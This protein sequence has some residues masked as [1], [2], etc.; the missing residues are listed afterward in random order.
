MPGQAKVLTSKEIASVFRV[1]KSN[2]DK[3]IFA[4]GLYAGLRVGEIIRLKPEQV[5]TGDGGIKNILKIV[6]L[7][8]KNTVYSDIP[9]HP[10]LRE[11]LKHYYQDQAPLGWGSGWLFPSDQSTHGHLGRC[12]AH[13]VLKEAFDTIRLEGAST[14]SMRRTCLTNMSRAGVPLRTIQDISGHSNLGQL[15]EYL[16]V[17]PADKHHA[18]SVLKY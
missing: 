14:H 17:D 2:R 7:K 16:A 13:N 12:Q 5:F 11:V 4:F 6:R 10:K 15:Q 3:L 9:T 18:I 8:K 1:L